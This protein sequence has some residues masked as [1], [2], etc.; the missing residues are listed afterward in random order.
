MEEEINLKLTI[1]EIDILLVCLSV[2][3]EQHSQVKKI[4]QDIQPKVFKQMATQLGIKNLDELMK[5]IK[6]NQ[7][8]QR[9]DL[10]KM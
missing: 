1:G 3:S 5:I 7:L 10:F 9:E 2:V 4:W 8:I 6:E